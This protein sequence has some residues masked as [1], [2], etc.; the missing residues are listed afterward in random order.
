MKKIL[1]ILLLFVGIDSLSGFNGEFYIQFLQ[2]D[3]TTFNVSATTNEYAWNWNGSSVFLLNSFYS[4]QATDRLTYVF[5]APKGIDVGDYYLPWGLIEFNI[6]TSNGKSRIFTIDFRDENWGAENIYGA[7]D[8]HLVIDHIN[9]RFYLSEKDNLSGY[10]I[11]IF[12]N[13]SIT[14]W[15]FWRVETGA[16]KENFKVPV[17]F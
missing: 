4:H 15:D 1:I 14:I 16:Y 11:Q 2:Y 17:K 8:T 13:S 5:D 9:D 7:P 6:T 10:N 3:G 12:N